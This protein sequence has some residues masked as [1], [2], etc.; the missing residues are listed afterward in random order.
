MGL[1]TL[2][3]VR[4]PYGTQPADMGVRMSRLTSSACEPRT[5]LCYACGRPRAQHECCL[6]LL[7]GLMG[8]RLGQVCDLMFGFARLCM[9]GA[10][11]RACRCAEKQMAVSSEPLG[12]RHASPQPHEAMA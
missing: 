11:L 6:C 4:H 9:L 12:G 7:E 3:P 8:G 1:A 2:A 10:V 5:T